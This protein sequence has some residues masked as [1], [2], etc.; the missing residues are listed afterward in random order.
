MKK[1]Y[2]TPTAEKVT[3]DYSE[4]VVASGSTCYWE[5]TDRHSGEG[6]NTSPVESSGHWTEAAN[7]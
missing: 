2:G 1:E 6:C 7:N 4:V 5:Q 3:F